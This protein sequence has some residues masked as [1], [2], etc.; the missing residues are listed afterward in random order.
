MSESSTTATTAASATSPIPAAAAELARDL[1][2]ELERAERLVD[3]IVDFSMHLNAED[4][5][6][7]EQFAILSGHVS[8]ILRRAAGR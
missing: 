7:V 8:V 6:L 2:D 3:R 1:Y 5:E 4:C